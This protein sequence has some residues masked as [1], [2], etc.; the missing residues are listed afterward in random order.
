MEG[1]STITKA[2]P[3]DIGCW[4]A[5]HNGR[6]ATSGLVFKAAGWGFPVTAEEDRALCAYDQGD[7]TFPSDEGTY[8]DAYDWVIELADRAEEW[9]NEHVAPEGHSFGWLDCEFFLWTDEE[10][11]AD[12]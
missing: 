11:A 7:D 6:Y 12:L 2:S 10:W 4:I 8:L 3:L 5:G 9:M 1:V